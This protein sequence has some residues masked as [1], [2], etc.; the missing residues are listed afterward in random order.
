MERI[1]PF[2]LFQNQDELMEQQEEEPQSFR[3]E[4][5]GARL[6]VF[7]AEAADISRNRVQRLILDGG[8]SVNGTPRRANHKLS[9]GDRVDML[10][11]PP[12]EI[13]VEAEDIPLPIVYEDPD[14]V[15]IDKPKGMV[16]HPAAG[17]QTGTMV[18]ALL[19]HVKDL[20][21]IGGV[22]RPG[23]VHRIDKYTSG[24]IVVA[25]NDLA[26]QSLSAQ[27]KAHT[28]GRTYLA[29]V[30]GNIR[31]DAGIIDQP[32]GRHPVDRK[33]MAIVGDG[34][35][36]VTHWRVLERLNQFTLVEAKLQTGRTHQI[37]VHM[38]FLKHP[39]AGDIVYGPDKPK[40]GLAGQALHAWKLTLMH[41][42]TGEEM[43]FLAPPPEDFL[44]ALKRAGWNGTPVWEKT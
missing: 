7:L 15:V 40:L 23:I 31:E 22:L 28:A 27:I 29:I 41:P 4:Q 5:S 12:E 19:Y 37:R 14:I 16:V 35:P 11:P 8:V 32:I 30:E 39:V 44:H 43:T 38:A 3:V 36:S 13:E 18:N 33:R 20:S 10:L 6:D 34:R 42:R 25:K 1:D 17:N 24:L 21:G 9:A 26:H 2:R